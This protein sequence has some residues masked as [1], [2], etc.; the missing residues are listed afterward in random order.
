ML[1]P[2][3]CWPTDDQT[4]LLRAALLDAET[5]RRAW[6]EWRA[7]HSLETADPASH[8]L[9]PLA[10]TNLRATGLDESDLAKLKGAY[11]AAW[12]RNQILFR[13]AAQALGV[14]H[15][16]GIPT[17]V[18][19]GIAL[20]VAH[21]R[22]EGVRPMED[23]DVL[24]PRHDFERAI[25]VLT[26]TG[27]VRG[28]DGMPAGGLGAVHAEHLRHREGGHSLDLHRYALAQ[29]A[30]DDAFWSDAVEVELLH[31][32]T[33]VL[34]PADQL[35]HVA[36]H[37]ARWNPV[38]PVRW[39]ADA[40]AIERSTRAGLDWDRLVEEASRRG[41]TT[42]LAAALE[43]LVAAVGFP[44][45][46]G[47]LQRLHAA[48]KGLL[49]RWAS[50]AALK[51]MGGGNWLP[52]ILDDYL[53]RSRVDRSVRPTGFLQEHFGVR[54]R[55]QLAVR[56][57]RKS[58]QVA[59]TQSAMRLAPNR[60]LACSKCGRLVVSLHAGGSVLCDSCRGYQ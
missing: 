39:L 27:W 13:Q 2:G 48:P 55:G 60:V 18:L 30:S 52:V 6:D 12:V 28:R 31:V 38:P 40:V 24:V 37:G 56:L 50:S 46:D 16:M 20:T 4:L 17:L 35:L 57:A 34:C 21:F 58:A 8:R 14:L 36:V 44:L 9:F 59:L 1:V 3:G 7:G 11:R 49:E 19:K 51:P 29:A 22:D 53:R 25:A 26:R 5:G 32:P 33:R 43:C 23:I 15:D 47:V 54:T 41:V 45:P 42:S 10:Y